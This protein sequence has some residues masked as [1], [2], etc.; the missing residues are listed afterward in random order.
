MTRGGQ[1]MADCR[2][3]WTAGS[4]E[5]G[6]VLAHA[7]AEALDLDDDGVV[8]QATEQCGGEDGS[9]EPSWLTR[10]SSLSTASKRCSGK[11]CSS[12]CWR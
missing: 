1:R 3:C 12:G 4:P 10:C 11:T 2:T 5:R 6:C 9:T 8:E 7:L